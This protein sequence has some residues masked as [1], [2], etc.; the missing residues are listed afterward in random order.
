MVGKGL[1]RE[2]FRPRAGGRARISSLETGFPGRARRP[3]RLARAW[4]VPGGFVSKGM[5]T[6]A[7]A[8]GD[9]G[10][11][12]ELGVD[13]KNKRKPGRTSGMRGL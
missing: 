11:D 1:S 13:C 4:P 6:E 8:G 3:P 10:R 5:R 7:T 2:T 9:R 12:G